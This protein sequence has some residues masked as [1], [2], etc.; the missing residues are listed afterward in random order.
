MAAAFM[1]EPLIEHE[2]VCVLQGKP[3]VPEAALLSYWL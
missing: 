3:S 2:P 1:A